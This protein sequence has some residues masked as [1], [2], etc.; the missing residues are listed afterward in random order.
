M[1]QISMTSAGVATNTVSIAFGSTATLAN[2]IQLSTTT[3]TKEFG[4]DT[5]HAYS[6]I[7]SVI[8]DNGSTTLR[9]TECR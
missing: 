6:G 4:M 7:V 1:L 9:I 5:I 2:G 8:T 3:P